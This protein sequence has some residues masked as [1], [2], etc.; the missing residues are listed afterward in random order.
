MGASF[1]FAR[2]LSTFYMHGGGLPATL[3]AL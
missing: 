3:Y 2:H 1:R